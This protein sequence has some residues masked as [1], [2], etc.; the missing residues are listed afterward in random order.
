MG[1]EFKY[2]GST[3][4][5][6]HAVRKVT[7]DL[8]YG[9]DL[10][11]PKMLY[12]KLLLSTIPHGI[13]KKIDTSRAE[14]VPGVVKIF[15]HLNAPDKMFNSY[16]IIPGQQLSFE[17]EPLFS[18]RVKYVGDRVA[19]VVATSFAA[20]MEAV[21]LIDVEYEELPALLTTEAA[22][23][24]KEVKIQPRGNLAHEYEVDAGEVPSMAD[25]CII[26]ESETQTQRTHHGALE[27]HVCIADY[28]SSGKLTVWTPTQGVFGVRTVLAELFGLSYSKVRVIKIPTGGSFGGKQEYLFEP[29]T[30]FMAMELKR[31]VKLLLDREECIIHTRVRPAVNTKI[32]TVVTKSGKLQEFIADS[33]LDAGAFSGSAP[34]YARSLSLKVTKLYRIPHYK[35][36]GRAVYTNTVKSGGARGWAAPEIITATEVHMDQVARRLKMDP[37]EF[38][39][40][41]LVHPYDMDPVL[42]LSVGDARVIECLE[43]GAEAFHWKERFSGC[44]TDEGRY[45]RGVGVA[46]GAHKN[47]M[48]GGFVDCTSM[49]LKMNEDGSLNLNASLH[50]VGCG[51][52]TAMKIIVAE[53][54]DIDP[55]LITVTE[56]D[57]EL[58]G[59]DPGCYGSRVTY[60][61]GACAKETAEILKD[62]ILGCVS[63]IL[64]KPKE[65]LKVQNGH[66][67]TIGTDQRGISYKEIAEKAVQENYTDLSVAHTYYSPSNPGSYSVQFAEVIVDSATGLTRVTDFLAVGDVGRVLNRGMVEGQFQGAVQMGIGYALCEEVKIDDQGKPVNNSFKKYHMVNAPD[68]PDVKVLLIEHEGDDG[69][70]GAKSVGEISAVPTA[71]AVINAV[72]HALGTSLSEMPLTPEKIL[73]APGTVPG[74]FL[75]S[76]M[77]RG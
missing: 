31:P 2:V 48:Y 1:K 46:C 17:D 18:R 67:V 27:P 12:A 29:V 73:D 43:K 19:A 5:C 14:K 23:E 68:M 35:H 37:V 11:L 40:Q 10:K 75:G 66:V 70:F 50:D 54:L 71:A 74:A 42:N 55:D 4:P 56:A 25:D 22:L 7:G 28:D 72:N 24:N 69:P 41:N 6:G 36:T 62:K 33:T 26:V 58:T 44:K 47:G 65:Y 76:K 21:S 16:R 13:V 53:V 20:A 59:Y 39:L 32:K 60:N 57:T 38:R 52:T 64:Q 30:S 49:V 61:V 9:C 45:R 51:T 8:L 3:Y 63:F 34:D 15:S 77:H